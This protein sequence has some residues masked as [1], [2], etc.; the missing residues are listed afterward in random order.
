[1][2]L[3]G[4]TLH[5]SGSGPKTANL[6]CGKSALGFHAD[7]GHG[8]RRRRSDPASATRC[9]A[10]SVLMSHWSTRISKIWSS[11]VRRSRTALS[12]WWNERNPDERVLW[13]S[14]IYLGEAYFNEIIRHPVPLDLNTLTALKRC[15][16]WAWISTSGRPTAPCAL[17]RPLRLTWPAP[18]PLS[19][20]WSRTDASGQ[21]NRSKLSAQD[22]AAN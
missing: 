21:K 16:Q 3:A 6:S 11:Q 2:H 22:P 10:S 18:V 9:G 5:R 19:S 8:A 12:F 20:E 1:M 14:K 7:A 4:L 13:D 15:S 17:T